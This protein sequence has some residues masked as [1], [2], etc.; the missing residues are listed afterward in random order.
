IENG[1]S[2]VPIPVTTT[3]TGPSTGLK[4][5]MPRCNNG[6]GKF[7]EQCVGKASHAQTQGVGDV[8][9]QDQAVLSDP[10]LCVMGG[11]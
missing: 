2:W 11:N 3:E 10:G 5:T 8:G 7:S 1:N 6:V 9:N 4:M